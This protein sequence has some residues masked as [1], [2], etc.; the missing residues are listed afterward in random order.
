MR[1]TGVMMNAELR[2][3]IARAM[4]ALAKGE[5]P[6]PVPPLKIEEEDCATEVEVPALDLPSRE[7]SI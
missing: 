4:T 2:R 5:K 3:E 7:S 6:P 1:E